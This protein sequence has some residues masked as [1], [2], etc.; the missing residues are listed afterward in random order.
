MKSLPLALAVSVQKF[1]Q[2]FAIMYDSHKYVCDKFEGAHCKE[3]A[4]ACRE[5]AKACAEARK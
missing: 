4:T 2:A 3:C 1:R 5:F